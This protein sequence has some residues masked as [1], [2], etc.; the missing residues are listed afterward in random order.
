M[1]DEAVIDEIAF[2]L[3]VP[4]SFVRSEEKLLG[5]TTNMT[6][7]PKGEH[8][9]Y[10]SVNTNSSTPALVARTT[11]AAKAGEI[12]TNEARNG[13]VLIVDKRNGEAGWA[14]TFAIPAASVPGLEKGGG[15]LQ[16]FAANDLG[17]SEK[18]LA[19]LIDVCT[20]LELVSS[21]K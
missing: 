15:S 5:G 7:S 16:C 2:S 21:S 1:V 18:M 11:V 17:H 10:V 6:W 19:F 13:G 3:S 8:S 12:M 14:V 4:K 20:S 9:P